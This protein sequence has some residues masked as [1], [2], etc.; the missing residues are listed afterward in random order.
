MEIYLSNHSPHL[1][2]HTMKKN[3][4]I[5]LTGTILPEIEEEGLAKGLDWRVP[6]L[7]ITRNEQSEENI[8]KRMI[9]LGRK[10]NRLRTRHPSK[11]YPDPTR[12]EALSQ[13][14]FP[15]Y[16]NIKG[17]WRKYTRREANELKAKIKQIRKY[18]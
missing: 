6:P 11:E 18:V 12:K 10:V 7:F 5:T 2:D 14:P 15:V 1:G 9:A 16:G 8:V 3:S 17:K 13:L 4:S